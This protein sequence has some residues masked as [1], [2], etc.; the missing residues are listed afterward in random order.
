MGGGGRLPAW[1]GSTPVAS[2]RVRLVA[3]LKDRLPDRRLDARPLHL[4][5]ESIW[6]T[7]DT[8]D[9]VPHPSLFD[10]VP[11]AVLEHLIEPSCV[12][13]KRAIYFD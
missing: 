11:L 13:E 4:D 2:I 3:G 5:D 1:G 12:G 9:H 8:D 6:K 10:G 7:A